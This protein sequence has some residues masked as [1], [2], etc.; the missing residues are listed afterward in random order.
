[1]LILVNMLTKNVK[2]RRRGRP[3]GE[4]AKGMAMR[5]R[6][7]ET[8]VALIAR[9]GYEAATLR[10]VAQQAG[11]SAALLYRYFPSKRAVVL[12]LYDQLSAEYAREAM[13]MNAGKWRERFVF[14]L[15][16]S[17][18]VLAPHRPSLRALIPVLV[19]GGDEGVFAAGTAFS[20]LRVQRVFEEAV[21]G[22][23]D[24]PPRPLAESLG[25]LL[26]LV[27]VLVLLWWLLDRSPK[28]RAT[29]GLMALFRQML[30]SASVTLRLPPVRRFVVAAD[31]LVSD[32]LFETP[33]AGR[34][35]CF[36]LADRHLL[37]SIV[38]W[39][40]RESGP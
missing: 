28:Q 39:P 10:E 7:Y 12:A 3:A 17:L 33:T 22:S 26:Y 16:I 31:A 40:R 6:L 30:P 15:Q 34:S 13:R 23:S 38:F 20:R 14:A 2:P 21:T 27:H 36:L 24:A 11:V 1:M 8:A 18:E 4:S 5:Q 32:A 9:H 35:L 29:T 37:R 25:R 19:S